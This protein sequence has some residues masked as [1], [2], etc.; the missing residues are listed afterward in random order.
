MRPITL[1]RYQLELLV[2]KD[3]RRAGEEAVELAR[4][5]AKMSGDDIGRIGG[6][7]RR[8]FEYN[9]QSESSAE[10]PWGELAKRTQEEREDLGFPPKHPI[11][12][13]T[14][15]Y[16][17]SWVERGH[18]LN[19]EDVYRF[20]DFET[21]LY[22][23]L[24]SEDPRVVPLSAGVE[25]RVGDPVMES[26]FDEI[27]MAYVGGGEGF[28]PP[29]PVHAIRPQFSRAIGPMIHAVL[30]RMAEQVKTRG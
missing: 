8:G 25:G 2:P 4:S 23:V 24:S 6:P 15:K 28:M 7:V 1:F 5:V 14:G 10:G 21:A 20:D 17:A 26:F 11:L 16:K 22:V 18:P 13:R 19:M 27:G 12:Q 9:F 30:G 3:V 29:R